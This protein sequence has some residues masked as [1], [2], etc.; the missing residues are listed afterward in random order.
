MN[1]TCDD[2]ALLLLCPAWKNWGTAK[3][4]WPDTVILHSREDDV[5]VF[6]DREELAKNSGDKLIE[7][8][9]DQRL[10]DSE[11]LAVMLWTSEVLGSGRTLA[12]LD[13][14]EL[15]EGRAFDAQNEASCI[16][17]ACGEETLSP[18]TS[19]KAS[20]RLTLRIF[21]SVVGPARFTLT[22]TMRE[23]PRCG[24]SQSRIESDAAA[25][26]VRH[27]SQTREARDAPSTA[28]P[29]WR[30]F[31]HSGCECCLLMLG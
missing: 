5:I 28:G 20:V 10:A 29:G 30:R 6:A 12:D 18:S 16:S 15:P 1:F 4:D 25:T 26:A 31:N 3:T 8:G 9:R 14:D 11:P 2:A 22:S 13:E 7:V 17:D 27:S 19:I 23:M 21:P 24:Q